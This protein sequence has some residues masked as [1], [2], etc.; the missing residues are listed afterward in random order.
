MIDRE[1]IFQHINELEK[2]LSQL[3]RYT[4]VSF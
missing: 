1:I 2:I 3:K 4:A